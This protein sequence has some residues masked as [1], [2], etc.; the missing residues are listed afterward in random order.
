[1]S[2]PRKSEEGIPV[3]GLSP[4]A[5]MKTSIRE[6]CPGMEIRPPKPA[7]RAKGVVIRQRVLSLSKDK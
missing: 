2:E 4:S 6:W 5:G 3:E 7:N 1:M